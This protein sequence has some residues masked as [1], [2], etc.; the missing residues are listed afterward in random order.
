[1]GQCGDADGVGLAKGR[2]HHV[3]ETCFVQDANLDKRCKRGEFRVRMFRRGGE[4]G[5]SGMHAGWS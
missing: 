4:L 5:V 1:M 2:K 3:P